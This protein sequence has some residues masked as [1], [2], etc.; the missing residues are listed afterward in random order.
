MKARLY[1]SYGMTKT[2]STLAFRLAQRFYQRNDCEQPLAPGHLLGEERRV[3]FFHL[4]TPEEL[5]GLEQFAKDH[6]TCLVIKTHSAP[7]PEM[8]EMLRAGRAYAHAVFRCNA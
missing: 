3:N 1:F 6:D 5:A 2:G 8:A 4:P 7:T